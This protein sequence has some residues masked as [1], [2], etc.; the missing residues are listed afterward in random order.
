LSNYF[1]L[2]S[3]KSPGKIFENRSTFAKVIIKHLV[4]YFFGTRCIIALAKHNTAIRGW[5]NFRF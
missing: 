1:D 3:F 5:A 4:A 2:L